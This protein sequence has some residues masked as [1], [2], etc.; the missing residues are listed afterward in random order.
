MVTRGYNESC[1]Y[2]RINLIDSQYCSFSVVI[3]LTTP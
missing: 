1:A 2:D 3:V